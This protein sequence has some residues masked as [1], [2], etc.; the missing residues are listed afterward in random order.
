MISCENCSQS[1]I[2]I[3]DVQETIQTPLGN[4]EF[5]SSLCN[6]CKSVVDFVVYQYQE[7][8]EETRKKIADKALQL[9]KK[10]R[11]GLT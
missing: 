9:R 3:T 7:L 6:R 8:Y 4:V 5:E 10:T 1:S 11:D 2:E